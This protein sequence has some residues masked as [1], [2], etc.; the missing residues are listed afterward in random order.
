MTVPR[1]CANN[2]D[3]TLGSSLL[4]C[5]RNSLLKLIASS[6][7]AAN[8]RDRF[9]F[10]SDDE[11]KVRLCGRKGMAANSSLDTALLPSRG[12]GYLDVA[13]VVYNWN[14]RAAFNEFSLCTRP[15]RV[16]EVC[17]WDGDVARTEAAQLGNSM[18]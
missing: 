2:E 6:K 10:D 11:V 12:K 5:N 8:W 3:D 17:G 16:L 4:S 18:L 7:M 14:V 13:D 15:V 9:A 1:G